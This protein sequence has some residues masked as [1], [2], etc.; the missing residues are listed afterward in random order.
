MGL[1]ARTNELLQKSEIPLCLLILFLIWSVGIS[2]YRSTDYVVTDANYA[3]TE[4]SIVI[5]AENSVSVEVFPKEK[6]L[7]SI[8][9]HVDISDLDKDNGTALIAEVFHDSNLVVSRDISPQDEDLGLG[10]AD[11]AVELEI[12]EEEAHYEKYRLVLKIN[13]D[14]PSG[15]WYAAKNSA[16]RELWSRCTYTL[17]TNGQRVI[18]DVTALWALLILAWLSVSRIK[19]KTP[20]SL[21]LLTSIVLGILY[22]FLLPSQLVPDSAN[23]FV[24][25]YLITKGMLLLPNGGQVNVPSNLLP[26]RN[27][28][29]TWFTLFHNFRNS[30]D[31]S[32]TESYDAVN[33]AL[34]SPINYIFQSCGIGLA[35][36]FSN[37]TYVLQMAGELVNYVGCTFIIYQAIRKI[38]YGKTILAILSLLP[39]A[40]QERMSLSADALSYASVVAMVA[41]AL[42]ERKSNKMMGGRDYAVMYALIILLASC[43]IVYFTAGLMILLIPKDRFGSHRKSFG[44]KIGGVGTLLA[45]SLGWLVIAAS[46]YLGNTRGGMYTNVKMDIIL[47][48]PARYVYIVNKMI[49]ENGIQYFFEM[50]GSKLGPTSIIVS[51]M[52]IF[53]MLL[54]LTISLWEER[55]TRNPRS[56]RAA[57]FM[58]GLS[59]LT[60]LL[61]MTSLYIQW[62]EPV[63]ATYCIEGIQGRY[64]L[65][66]MPIFLMAFLVGE[67][68]SDGNMINAKR[69]STSGGAEKTLFAI[70]GLNLLTLVY[71]WNYQ[72]YV[73]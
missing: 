14:A 7:R 12:P 25:S 54:I 69:F 56:S 37:N 17:L 34:Y 42:Y 60:A 40:M 44:H 3:M 64:F 71:I 35:G 15:I 66:I 57:L 23:H 43:K 51:D 61:V 45:F 6:N 24:R 48:Q 13:P 16:T 5:S 36:V 47:H 72:S 68:F 9:I 70:Y 27:Y 58:F 10:D 67:Y 41:F 55:S 62:T 11:R 31:W 8:L 50:A 1:S 53:T 32:H 30:I 21:F 20:E 4:D 46:G 26:Y 2:I 52:V 49:L 39:M 73:G 63:S 65:P 19:K 33:M 18:L 59:A 29:Y 28:S 22:F 38:P